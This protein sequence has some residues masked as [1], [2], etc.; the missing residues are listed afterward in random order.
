MQ[1]TSTAGAVAMK[2]I[3]PALIAALLCATTAQAAEAR[4]LS[5]IN[6]AHDSVV[7]VAVAPAGQTTFEPRPIDMLAGGGD[8]TTVRLAD[9]GCRFDLR[10][11]FR[12]GRTA[13]YRDVDVC[14]GDALVIAPLPRRNATQG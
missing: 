2:L 7:A 4:Y 11:Q 5:L 3:R 10:L 14:T 12:N 8:A 13:I 6:R 1:A 9:S